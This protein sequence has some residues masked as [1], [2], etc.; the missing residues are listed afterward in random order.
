MA[1]ELSL[2]MKTLAKIFVADTALINY[3]VSHLDL[4]NGHLL[5]I[6]EEE[7]YETRFLHTRFAV[8]K[9]KTRIAKALAEDGIEYPDTLFN[10]ELSGY[11]KEFIQ[12]TLKDVWG[13]FA[14]LP[15]KEQAEMIDVLLN[16][17]KD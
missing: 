6:G 7:W 12:K 1:K 13:T 15:K 3:D 8:A 10:Q 5:K 16:W 17:V 4:A 9:K 11:K 2:T 14:L